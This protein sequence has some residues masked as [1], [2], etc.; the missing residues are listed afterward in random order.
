VLRF[1]VFHL[2]RPQAVTIYSCRSTDEPFFSRQANRRKRNKTSSQTVPTSEQSCSGRK[3]LD[4]PDSQDQMRF[5]LLV[6][7][8]LDAA[9]NLARWLLR[10][11][12]D[13]EDAAQE[14]MLRAYRFFHRFHG[15]DVRAWLLQIVRNTCYTWLE[16]NRHVK[17]MTQFDEDLHGPR[18][19]TPEAL[20]IAGDNRERLG[21]ALECLSP[22]FR[23]VIVLR[24]LEGCSYKEIATITSI[25][26]GTVMSTLSRARRQLHMALA[27]PARQEIQHEL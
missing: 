6:L 19:P 3:G 11:G 4:A 5:E 27:G 26:I 17:D 21:H 8:H 23:E 13:A 12:A 1:D 16:K 18:S 10:S 25:P 7:P 24:E 20:A 15:G 22:R 2:C 14:A 9:F